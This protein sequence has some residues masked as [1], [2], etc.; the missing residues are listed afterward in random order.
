MAIIDKTDLPVALQTADSIDLMVAGA[1]AAAARVAPCLVATDPPPS[2]EQLAEARLILLGMIQRW[3]EAGSGAFQQ[4]TAGPFGVVVDTRQKSS[5][6]RP[7]PSEIADLQ[8]LCATDSDSRVTS[9]QFIG[10]RYTG[11][12]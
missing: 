4:Q 7:W 8:T 6:F 2:N 3:T 12:L 9:V 10:E 1:N 11:L 5:G